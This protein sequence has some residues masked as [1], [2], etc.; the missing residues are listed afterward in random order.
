MAYDISTA[1][2]NALDSPERYGA[3][4][5]TFQ[6]GPN[7][8]GFWTGQGSIVYNSIT[9]Y[10]G[11]SL[12]ELE[13]IQQDIDGS[14]NECNLKLS[15]APDKGLDTDVLLSFYDEDWQFGRVVIQLAMLDPETGVPIGAITFIRGVIYEA[16]FTRDV[17]SDYISARVVSQSIKL[18]ENGGIYRND[19]T[20]HRLDSDDTSL[21]GIGS[22]G[23]ATKKK[24]KWGQS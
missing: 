21:V 5:L 16:P 8:Y 7:T 10:N 2:Q 15:T 9:Y 14:V 1:L 17:K 6:L 4:F 3:V 23:G 20:Q 19:A 22:L 24:L 12:F 18:S 13:D 11:G